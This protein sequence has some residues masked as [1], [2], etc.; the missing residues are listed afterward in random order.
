MDH[1]S[2]GKCFLLIVLALT[3][4]GAAS[5]AVVPPGAPTPSAVEERLLSQIAEEICPYP[6]D[7]GRIDPFE[8]YF[9]SNDPFYSLVCYP[10]TGH[11]LTV[12]IRR[13]A[14][15]A[16][17]MAE[18]ESGGTRGLRQEVQGFPA[19]DWEEDY[20]S[21]PGGRKEVRVRLMQAG[22]WLI[23]IEAFDDTRFQ[24]APDPRDVS[25]AVVRAVKE[26]GSPAGPEGSPP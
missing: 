23:R 26:Q 13:F 24:I 15:P 22:S 18:F 25:Q 16:H 11:S 19:S 4:C 21:F 10:A 5:T 8:R 6:D 12:T 1:L 14:G 17:A 7:P 9:T 3:S 20:P 2:P